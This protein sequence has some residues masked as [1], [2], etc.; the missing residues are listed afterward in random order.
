MTHGFGSTETNLLAK[1]DW[2]RTDT[3]FQTP[4]SKDR[5]PV[6]Y[7]VSGKK[8]QIVDDEERPVAPGEEGELVVVSRHIFTGYWRQ[9]EITA[10][11]LRQL[12]NGERAY[13]T[14]DLARICKDCDL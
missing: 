6:G 12:P 7:P 9:P 2:R 10:Q 1:M 4:S 13:S 5:L 8:I 11:C 14:G 3:V